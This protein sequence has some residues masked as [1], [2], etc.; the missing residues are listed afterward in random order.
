VFGRKKLP[1][2]VRRL[3]L[4]PGDILV[5]KYD[6]SLTQKDCHE[7][8]E[9]VEAIVGHQTLVLTGGMDID[10]L[11]CP[12]GVIEFEDKLSPAEAERLRHRWLRSHGESQS[13]AFIPTAGGLA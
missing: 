13:S 11:G 6:G 7:L 4:E 9:R 2:E 5:L 1:V 10:V 12:T 8:K 3:K